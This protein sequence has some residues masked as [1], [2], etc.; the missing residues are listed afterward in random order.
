MNEA[1][2]DL[3]PKI[4]KIVSR[5]FIVLIT[6]NILLDFIFNK[7]IDSGTI[8]WVL[9]ALFFMKKTCNLSL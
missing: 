5:L 9:I 2:V 8:F 6:A 4:I 1:I 7:K 3:S